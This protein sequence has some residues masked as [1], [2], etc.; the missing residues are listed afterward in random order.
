MSDDWFQQV[1]VVMA[2][3]LVVQAGIGVVLVLRLL[4]DATSS[5]KRNDWHSGG[6]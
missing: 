2:L 1:L 3:Q 6:R 4:L 5:W